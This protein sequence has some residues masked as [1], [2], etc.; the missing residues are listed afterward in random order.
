[1]SR[2]NEMIGHPHKSVNTQPTLKTGEPQQWHLCGSD[3]DDSVSIVL[4][5]FFV[6]ILVDLS[7][8]SRR[9]G[10]HSNE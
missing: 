6:P 1:M 8:L 3:E 2:L 7:F 4:S 9:P 5:S 10:G